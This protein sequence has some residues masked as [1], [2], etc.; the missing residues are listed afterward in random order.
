MKKWLFI[1]VICFLF[2]PKD[3]FAMSRDTFT[4]LNNDGDT[5][6]ASNTSILN[7]HPAIVNYS[8]WGITFRGFKTSDSIGFI[9]YLTSLP[10]DV[11]TSYDLSFMIYQSNA[12]VPTSEPP[13]V[14]VNGGICEVTPL[15]YYTSNTISGSSNSS[16][17]F[18]GG[19]STNPFMW[20]RYNPNSSGQLGIWFNGNQTINYNTQFEL[21][22]EVSN[23]YIYGVSCSNVTIEEENSIFVYTALHD[24]FT[25]NQF[26][27]IS[28]TFYYNINSSSAIKDSVDD[29]NES[30]TDSDISGASDSAGGFF[31]DFEND[32]YG[33]SDIVTLPLTFIQ[34]L[35]N[36]SCTDLKLPL[37]FVDEDVELPCMSAIYEDYFG[38]FLTIYQ[39][40]TF[41]IVGYWVCVNTLRLVNN[42]KNPDND[43]V[44]VMDL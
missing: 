13:L 14:R 6:Y 34:G 1:L 15:G 20:Y 40:I 19:S 38:A 37:P 17:T 25:S 5:F 26:Y 33:L 41:G 21:T 30:I 36:A 31:T 24:A 29:L 4:I 12:P 28:P 44:E 22:Q 43:E 11:S 3:V 32:D 16:I 8:G 7:S 2:M 42:F 10:L 27:G 23:S 9:R 39:I 18:P 35:S